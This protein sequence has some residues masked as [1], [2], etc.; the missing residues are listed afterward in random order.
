MIVFIG[1]INTVIISRQQFENQ[2][3]FG[4]NQYQYFI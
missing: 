1:F 4:G 2:F 3:S